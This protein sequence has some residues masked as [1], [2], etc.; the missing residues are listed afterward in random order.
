MWSQVGKNNNV[1]LKMFND[2][3]GVISVQITHKMAVKK[4]NIYH[5]HVCRKFFYVFEKTITH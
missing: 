2:N 4:H 1:Y 3:N 5:D